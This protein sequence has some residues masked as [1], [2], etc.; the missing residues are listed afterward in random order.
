MLPEP[1]KS[2]AIYL[3]YLELGP[4]KFDVVHSFTFFGSD[5]NC[6]NDICAEIQKH[7]PAATRC[8]DGLT[9]HLRSQLTLKNT[10]LLM[11][12]IIIRPLL[13][14][15]SKIWTLYKINERRLSLF[16]RKVLRS[17]FGAK[18]EKEIW[19]K[20][21]SYELYETLKEPNIFNYIK[22]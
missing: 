10:K 7:I 2:H 13:I 20:R 6:N 15:A 12:K 11:Y 5:D 18:Q 9:K 21:Y 8:L 1:K 22:V 16:E 4:F 14:C 19:R 17:I 3:H